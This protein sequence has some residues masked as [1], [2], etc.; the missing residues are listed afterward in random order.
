[1]VCGG[2][3]NQLASP[4][5]G[6]LLAEHSV[7]YAPDFCVNC[8]GVIQVAEELVGADVDKARAKVEQVFQTTADV[9]TRAREEGLTPV[10]AAEREA[11]TRIAA[12]PVSGGR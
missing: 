8:G 11:E 10:R 4:E 1:L 6:D 2:A 9:L 7:L 12:G 3:N 5:V